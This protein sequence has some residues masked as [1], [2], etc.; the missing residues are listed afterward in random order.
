[1]ILHK[2]IFSDI[3]FLG[4]GGNKVTDFYLRLLGLLIFEHEEPERILPFS[5]MKTTQ[6]G[7]KRISTRTKSLSLKNLR[8]IQDQLGSY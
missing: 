8:F 5:W 7:Q 6:S 3:S 1:M 4:R 2:S